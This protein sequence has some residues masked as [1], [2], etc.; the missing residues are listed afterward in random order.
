MEVADML[1]TSKFSQSAIGIWVLVKLLLPLRPRTIGDNGRITNINS[2]WN[3]FFVRGESET[4]K[5]TL[6]QTL[7]CKW[8]FPPSNGMC[9]RRGITKLN[10]HELVIN[11]ALNMVHDEWNCLIG[12]Y[13]KS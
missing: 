6:A 5:E 12:K 11:Y 10:L 1:M 4:S 7:T 13:F 9:D 3:I 8:L 2:I